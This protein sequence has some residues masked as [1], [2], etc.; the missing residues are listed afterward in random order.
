MRSLVGL[1]LVPLLLPLLTCL[2]ALG[3]CTL[4][5]M[6]QMLWMRV[7]G[8][9]YRRVG[10]I[11]PLR[12]P[13]VKVDQ[14]DGNTSYRVILRNLEIGGL[15]ASKVESVRIVRGRLR[16]N[17]SDGEAG[18]VSYNEQRD[19]DSIRYRFHTLVKEPKPSFGYEEA[20]ERS[21]K[22]VEYDP[23][24][25]RV[26]EYEGVVEPFR[27]TIKGAARN[28][29]TLH[30]VYSNNYKAT[31][32]SRSPANLENYRPCIGA[33]QSYPSQ[34][35]QF[36]ANDDTKAQANIYPDQ[37][38]NADRVGAESTTADYATKTQFGGPG[39]SAEASGNAQRPNHFSFRRGNF[40]VN[41]VSPSTRAPVDDQYGASVTQVHHIDVEE[42]TE[43]IDQRPV[44][45]RENASRAAAATNQYRS[46]RVN[47]KYETA[48]RDGNSEWTTASPTVKTPEPYKA[49]LIRL[50]K[51]PGY[52]DI[53]YAGGAKPEKQPQAEKLQRAPEDDPRAYGLAEI[54][55]DLRGHQRYII[56]NFT[57]GE[58]LR[59]RN[60][61][62]RVA[63]ESKRIKDL[64]RYAKE[65]EE[66]AGYFEEGVELVYHFGDS[67]NVSSSNDR[68]SR[69]KRQHLED[70]DE[71]D[72]MHVVVR[73][74]V[75]RL[76]VKS[77]YVLT[78]K[79]GKQLLRGNGLLAGN[80]TD[81]I[82]DFTV[83]LKKVNNNTM[84]V[85]AARAKLTAKDHKIKLQGMDEKGPVDTILAHGLMA[86]EA[87]A[88]MIAD[89]LATKALNEG[90][91]ENV[92]YKMYKN[93]PAVQRI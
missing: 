4:L 39:F 60:D 25:V 51:Q 65:Y 9:G 75:P 61:A 78:G 26:N 56:H 32:S 93:L 66:K 40:E 49:P 44:Y 15:N 90:N 55:K 23:M 72:L 42:S 92:I 5:E 50:E 64:I 18:Y 82:A 30:L 59:K 13:V 83:E 77:S 81:L 57:E 20:H 14:S 74:R 62:V 80:F 17:L 47:V 38:Y 79:V 52:V 88:A 1:R 36:S 53:V 54:L 28:P 69:T 63:A 58:S 7:L 27:S 31:G 67:Q 10:R 22:I 24:Y 11:D 16:S 19:L 73:V 70:K 43:R 21:E 68:L 46:D 76:S 12:V 71:D 34:G 41:Y 8:G 29:A 45:V 2:V 87:V 91:A 86:A 84:I 37:R 48:T 3:N 33:C 85:R 89:D 35:T 6:S